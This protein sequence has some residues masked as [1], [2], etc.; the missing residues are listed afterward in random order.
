MNLLKRKS[1][2]QISQLIIL[3]IGCIL[4]EACAENNCSPGGQSVVRMTFINS[5]TKE[6]VTLFDSLTVTALGTDSILINR[7]SHIDHLSLPLSYTDNETHFVLHYNRILRDTINL[8]HENIPHFISTDCG[9]GMFHKLTNLSYT[10]ILIDSIRLVN[11]DVNDY[12]KENY[13]I[14][15]T[16]D[17]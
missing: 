16:P 3:A 13:R 7:D 10:Q 17:E 11:S 1:G 6:P 4:M 5:L 8:T 15:Y 2:F 12:E 9:V 14:Y